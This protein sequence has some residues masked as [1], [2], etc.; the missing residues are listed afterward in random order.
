MSDWFAIYEAQYEDLLERFGLG[1][2]IPSINKLEWKVK[3]KFKAQRMVLMKSLKQELVRE[4]KRLIHDNVKTLLEVLV[5]LT[6]QN[7]VHL[8]TV[9]LKRKLRELKV[10]GHTKLI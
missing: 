6:G 1:S 10:P 7:D 5:D 9:A 4:G 2:P 8:V 3:Y